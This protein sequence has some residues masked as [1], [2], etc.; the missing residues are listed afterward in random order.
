MDSLKNEGFNEEPL[1][2]INKFKPMEAKRSK[3]EVWAALELMLDKPLKKQSNIISINTRK[4]QIAASLIF[5]LVFASV[6]GSRFYKKTVLALPGKQELA[7]LPDG[8]EVQ[9]NSKS[10]ISY[11]PIWWKVNREVNLKG[12]AFFKVKKGKKFTVV[13]GIGTT[14]VVGTSFNIFARNNN[15]EVTC[16]TGKVKVVSLKTKE[17]TLI[18]P[19]QMIKL[20]DAG[21][22][23]LNPIVNAK[24][25]TYW[26]IGK[27][28]FTQVPLERVLSEIALRYNVKIK[29]LSNSN[30]LYTGNFDKN[31][32]IELALNLVCK[33]FELEYK[34]LPSGEY[35]IQRTP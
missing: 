4:W 32:N 10:E 11:N 6:L 8:S 20:S 34:K 16:L 9:L 35:L 15:Y 13:S 30:G 25:T 24:L 27:F 29:N 26:S 22:I 2:L 17:E 1:N 33:P 18:T 23:Q 12:E 31:N 7:I 3:E 5:V 14:T 21:N 19:N 28:V